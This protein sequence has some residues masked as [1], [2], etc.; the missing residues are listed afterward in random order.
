LTIVTHQE[1]LPRFYGHWG[2][3]I[4]RTYAVDQIAAQIEVPVEVFKGTVLVEFL[5]GF[6]VNDPK[7]IATSLASGTFIVNDDSALRRNFDG[8]VAGRKDAPDDN[9][10]FG[11]WFRTNDQIPLFGTS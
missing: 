7:G 8:V 11:A 2:H 10:F 3:F 4:R 6:G 5:A 1:K 9:S